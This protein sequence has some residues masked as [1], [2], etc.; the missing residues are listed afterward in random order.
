MEVAV[1]R[2]QETGIEVDVAVPSACPVLDAAVA[3][4]F[5]RLELRG[6]GSA[7][8]PDDTVADIPFALEQSSPVSVSEVSMNRI[9]L[10]HAV[11]A[12]QPSSIGLSRVS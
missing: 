4:F 7:V 2:V 6:V 9:V 11:A 12:E 10:D 8:G 3:G 1:F 5:L